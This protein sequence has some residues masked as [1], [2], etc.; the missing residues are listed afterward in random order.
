[1]TR[2]FSRIESERARA[3]VDGAAERVGA[4]VGRVAL[5]ELELVEHRAGDASGVWK[6]PV[7]AA[8]GVGNETAV[9]GDAMS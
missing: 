3:D 1:V 9:D 2:R 5:D 6:L 7:H 8:D 4:L